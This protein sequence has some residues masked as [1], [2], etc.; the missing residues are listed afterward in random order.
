MIPVVIPTATPALRA[1]CSM[2]RA[3]PPETATLR[4]GGIARLPHAAIGG[5]A[6]LRSSFLPAPLSMGEEDAGEGRGW[7]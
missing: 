7:F 4:H 5:G 2:P 1:L 3:G 6:L